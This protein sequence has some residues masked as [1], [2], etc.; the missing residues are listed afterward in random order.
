M[1]AIWL[2]SVFLGVVANA[3]H[4]VPAIEAKLEARAAL[5]AA[6]PELPPDQRASLR[7][8]AAGDDVI[9]RLV[10]GYA[11]LWLAALLGAC[12]MAAVMASDSQILAL[13]TMFTEDVFAFYGGKARFGEAVQVQMGRLFVVLIT[14][15][16]YLIALR[17][18]QSIF[19]VATQYAFAGYAALSPAAGGG[20]VLA[21]QHE[22][23][24]V[25][26]HRL[27]GA[28]RGV[29]RGH[30][31]DDS[32][33]RRRR[34]PCRCSSIGGIDVIARAAAGTRSSACCRSCR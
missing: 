12:V 22:M 15:V 18:P 2:P 5:A 11:P 28:G 19:D 34:R 30:P 20:A 29:G 4:D 1:L 10:E 6:G 17:M 14:L 26:Q 8:Q 3:A 27:D 21:R 13:S 31:A 9:L 32:P 7:A 23:G 16:A 25:R 33:A 24:R